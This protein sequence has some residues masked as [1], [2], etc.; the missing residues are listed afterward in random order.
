LGWLAAMTLLD[1]PT[2]ST[3][4]GPEPIRGRTGTVR[5]GGARILR[6]HRGRGYDAAI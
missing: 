4:I 5:G 6:S 1:S 2:K 3:T